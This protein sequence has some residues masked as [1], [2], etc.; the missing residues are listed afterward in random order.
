MGGVNTR[1]QPLHHESVGEFLA[2]IARAADRADLG[3]AITAIQGEQSRNIYVNDA[4][5]HILGYSREDIMGMTI[6]DSIAPEDVEVVSK[7]LETFMRGEVSAA[8]ASCIIVQKSGRRRRLDYA[9]A[10]VDSLGHDAVVSFFTDVT[11]RD[12]L[13][14]EALQNARLASV[15]RLAAGIAHE[16]N[17]PLAYVLL[18]VNYLERALSGTAVEGQVLDDLRG[19]VAELSEGVQRVAGIVGDL[20]A[21][22]RAG[23]DALAPVD[24]EQVMRHAIR[25]ARIP[26]RHR[27]PRQ[28]TTVVERYAKA[29][30]VHANAARLGQV[31]VNLLLN[32]VHAAENVD[33]GVVEVRVERND[34][35]DVVA[36]VRDNGGG[37]PKEDQERIFDPFYTTK[38][39]G[40]G[41]GLG[42]SI[43]RHIVTEMGGELMVESEPGC[44]ATFRV[45]LP[46]HQDAAF[47]D[48]NDAPPS[49]TYQRASKRQPANGPPPAATTATSGSRRT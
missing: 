41:T 21:F 38:D 6:Y 26:S 46:P 32:A 14:T 27:D 40:R 4:A 19:R 11:E 44:G 17:N 48:E 29:P 13:E 18:N 45:V 37:I 9:L 2:A 33:G 5:C 23:D 7:R 15:G 36:E 20:L 1:G 12:A 31:F 22:S 47:D 34:H 30:V 35:G 3:V 16:I 43:S 42:L 39:S 8:R 28:R 25:F 24:V 49:D 10:R